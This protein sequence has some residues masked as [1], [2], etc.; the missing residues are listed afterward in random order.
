[1]KQEKELEGFIH[2]FA[3]FIKLNCFERDRHSRMHVQLH[4]NLEL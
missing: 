3:G 1:M 2:Q 4:F